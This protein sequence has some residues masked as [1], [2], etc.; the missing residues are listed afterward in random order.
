MS[1]QGPAAQIKEKL[2]KLNIEKGKI[3]RQIG[4]LKKSNAPFEATLAEMQALSIEI[5]SL[6]S[7]LRSQKKSNSLLQASHALPTFPPHINELACR[8]DSTFPNQYLIREILSTEGQEWNKYVEAHPASCIYHFFDFKSIIEQSFSHKALYFAAF[9]HQHTIVGIMPLIHTKSSLFGSYMTSIP[10]FNY[11]GPLSDNKSVEEQLIQHALSCSQQQRASHVEIR[12]SAPRKNMPSKTDKMSLFLALP[13]SK[14]QLWKDIGTKVRA[15]I[16]KGQKN[17]LLF[18]V[19]KH[20]LLDDF[21]KVFSINMRDLGTPV[22]S[23]LFFRNILSSK[24]NTTLAVQYYQGSPISCAFLMSYKD[25]LEIPWASTLRQTNKLNSN[26]V[27]YWNILQ[28]ACDNGYG[29]FDFGR[30]SKEA[31][32]FKFKSQWG[33]KPAQLHWHYLLPDSQTLPNLN[34][35]NPKLKLAIWCWSK[36]P[37]FIANTIGP[38]LARSLP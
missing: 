33:A 31:P 23:K 27:L 24:L 14:E 28:Y 36:L 1:D 7:E 5:K 8:S 16:K 37:L 3:S 11:G 21:Y 9:D 38:L 17:Q 13:E 10:Y 15:Q 18:K 32:T 19:G 2:K 22:Y 29:F 4:K 34:P 25:C 35:G 30:S 20:E 26:M 12:E 6:E